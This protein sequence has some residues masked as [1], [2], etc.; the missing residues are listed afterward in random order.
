MTP[1]YYFVEV[2]L[3][4]GSDWALVKSLDGLKDGY[5]LFNSGERLSYEQAAARLIELQRQYPRFAY[6]LSHWSPDSLEVV[7]P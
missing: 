5:I 4:I 2:R 7:A 3:A 1:I 6:R